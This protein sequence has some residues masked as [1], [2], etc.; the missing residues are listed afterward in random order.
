MCGQIKGGDV[1][2]IS[3]VESK[4]HLEMLSE[5]VDMW[6]EEKMDCQRRRG[7]HAHPWLRLAH[8]VPIVSKDLRRNFTKDH[9]DDAIH[10]NHEN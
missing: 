8:R 6:L 5:F 3:G 10:M 1:R 4:R 9:E 2:V 7:E